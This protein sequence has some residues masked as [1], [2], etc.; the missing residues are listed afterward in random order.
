MLSTEELEEFLP[1]PV[2]IELCEDTHHFNF[3]IRDSLKKLLKKHNEEY[4]TKIDYFPRF[5]R[6]TD[7]GTSNITWGEYAVYVGKNIV[8]R[9]KAPA[10]ILKATEEIAFNKTIILGAEGVLN[11]WHD[12]IIEIQNENEKKIK[13]YEEDGYDEVLYSYYHFRSDYRAF[14]FLKRLA[15]RYPNSDYMKRL[16][17]VYRHGAYGCI[18][19]NAAMLNKLSKQR[20]RENF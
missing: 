10:D 4:A 8:H 13:Q 2:K 15:T 3:G 19:H 16:R 17:S 1:F 5:F 12:K 6:D 18:K 9:G 7:D 20:S 11:V 14:I